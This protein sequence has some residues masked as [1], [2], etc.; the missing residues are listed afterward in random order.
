[1]FDSPGRKFAK[2]LDTACIEALKNSE[3]ERVLS[4]VS[5]LNRNV[6][7]V[8]DDVISKLNPESDRT[9]INFLTNMKNL[10]SKNA[11][12]R[13]QKINEEFDSKYPGISQMERYKYVYAE[14]CKFVQN[15][16]MPPFYQTLWAL[17]KSSPFPA[18]AFQ[19][20]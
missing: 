9:I 6:A 12:T 4:L 7:E 13:Q 1:M 20:T 18:A 14:M 3:G 11:G 8:V 10:I 15:E 19:P 17:E 16:L 5:L 2:R